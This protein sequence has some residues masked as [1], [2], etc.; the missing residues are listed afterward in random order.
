MSNELHQ[1]AIKSAA[2]DLSDIEDLKAVKLNDGE[3]KNRASDSD[4]F[5]KNHFE[6]KLKLMINT[7]L[8]KIVK[9]AET[10]FDLQYCRGICNGFLL[11][12]EWFE[13]QR[14]ISRA[15]D[16]KEEPLGLTEL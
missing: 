12:K 8:E 15:G 1:S 13:E 9:E 5:Y 7:Q 11:V 16:D 10:E 4:V 2:I 14:A 6:K 3:Y